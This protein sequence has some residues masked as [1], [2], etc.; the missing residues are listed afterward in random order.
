MVT[1]PGGGTAFPHK[2]IWWRLKYAALH[3]TDRC[4]LDYTL[5]IHNQIDIDVS[6]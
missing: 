5:D 4:S 6:K 1:I 2:S 3:F